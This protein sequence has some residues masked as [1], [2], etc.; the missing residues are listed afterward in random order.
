[1]SRFNGWSARGKP[2]KRFF[3]ILAFG[4]GLKPGVNEM[5]FHCGSRFI[6]NILRIER[7]G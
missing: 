1:M 4:T 7:I 2:S 3:T 5:I 6:A